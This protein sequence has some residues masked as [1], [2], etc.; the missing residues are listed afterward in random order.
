MS[1]YKENKPTKMGS[2][3][4]TGRRLLQQTPASNNAG[5][6]TS[7]DDEEATTAAAVTTNNMFTVSGNHLLDNHHFQYTQTSS[8]LNLINQLMS[9]NGSTPHSFGGRNQHRHRRLRHRLTKKPKANAAGH[10]SDFA[11][12]SFASHFFMA[13]RRF[14]SLASQAQTFLFGD[15]LDLAFVLSHKPA[16]V[17]PYEAP[18]VDAPS[19]YLQSLVNIR[20][21]TLKLVKCADRLGYVTHSF[22]ILV[23]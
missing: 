21:D 6:P 8:R 7:T 16:S 13:G 2:V 15:Q 17:F 4:S 1:N 10:L 19:S 5:G 23:R 9:L 18:S 3:V 22:F 11:S 12:I 20:K 14:K